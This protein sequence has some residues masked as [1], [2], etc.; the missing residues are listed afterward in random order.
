MS[1]KANMSVKLTRGDRFRKQ[2]NINPEDGTPLVIGSAK[3]RYFV[4]R[5]GV[6]TVKSPTTG[7]SINVNG[8]GWKN[9]LKNGDF[10]VEELLEGKLR[11]LSVNGTFYL[12]EDLQ[13]FIDYYFENHSRKAFDKKKAEIR[14][15]KKQ[16]YAD[17]KAKKPKVEKKKEES[18]EEPKVD[19]KKVEVK[20]KEVPK[21]VDKKVV[22]EDESEEEKVVVGKKKVEVKKDKEVEVKE[23]EVPKK[24]DKKV[25]KKV[26][27]EN[28]SEEEKV[29]GK[30]KVEVKEKE[31]PKKVVKEKN[32]SEEEVAKK[33]V[34]NITKDRF[35]E[36]SLDNINAKK[37]N[38]L[39]DVIKKKCKNAKDEDIQ[40]NFRVIHK[41][42]DVNYEVVFY[43]LDN[44]DE[45]LTIT[46]TK[47][48]FVEFLVNVF[49]MFPEGRLTDT[50]DAITCFEDLS[51]RNED[52]FDIFPEW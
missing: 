24:V 23:K 15:Q 28:E 47:E 41:K 31:V 21:K 11:L 39:P 6:P 37:M 14:E 4:E 32:L 46:D 33:L 16:A 49:K 25:D 5:H 22:K 29:V 51:T 27:K 19:K 2:P 48:G 40:I 35:S 30:K 10:T 18:E 12:E 52:V 9:F 45:E 34:A 7:S 43:S 36:F 50:D 13:M 1:T 3:F 17:S 44:P 26:V 42:K 20:E 8:A 38:F